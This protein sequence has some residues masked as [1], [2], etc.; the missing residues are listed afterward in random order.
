MNHKLPM[1]DL[2]VVAVLPEL[3]EALAGHGRAVLQ[4]PPG[5]GK[6]TLVP[7]F[8]LDQPW[9]GDRKTRKIQKIVMLEPRR[10]AAR[11]CAGF[12]ADLLGEAVGETVGYRIRNERRVSRR[13][14]IEVVT[15]GILTRMI[16][17]DPALSDIGALIFD[18]FHERHIQSDLGLALSLESAEVLR[19]DLKILVM[20]AT[21]DADALSA[22]MDGA[23][24]VR[25]QGRSWPVETI[26][27]PPDTRSPGPDRFRP[28]LAGC[29]AAVCH[30]LAANEGDIL[31]FLP[32][33]R[34]IRLTGEML[35]GRVGPDVR[36][37][38]LFGMLSQAD[39]VAAIS[40]SL[41]G[42]RKVV[43]ASAIAETSLTIEGVSI[44]VDSGLMRKPRF[45]PGTG[46]S[47]L[48]TLP[49]SRASADQRRGR[50]GRT[51]PGICYRIW[52]EHVH[53]GLIP[54][55]RP[56]ILS[57][58]LAGTALELALWGVSDP[59]GL[60]W[61]DLPPEAEFSRARD[62]LARLGALDGQ[63][64]ITGHGK[65][66]ARAGLHPRLAH[67][68][69]RA[70]RDGDGMLACRLAALLEERDILSTSDPDI[71]LRLEILETG[72]KHREM[73][74]NRHLVTTILKNAKRLAKNLAV[75]PGRA[76]TEA[77]AR[78]LAL[79]YPERVGK[80]RRDLVYGLASG[81][82]ACFRAPNTV[83]TSEYIVAAHLDGNPRNARIFL[84]APLDRADLE[85][86][87]GDSIETRD[88]LAWDPEAGAVRALRQTC[89]GRLVLDETP[90]SNPDPEAVKAA[91][92]AGIRQMGPGC[93]PWTRKLTG[94]CRRTRFLRENAGFGDLPDLE[95]ARLLATLEDWLAPFLDGIRSARDLKRLD[96]SAALSSLFT[97]DQQQTVRQQAPTHLTV[98]SGSKIPLKYTDGTTLLE[99]PVLAVRLQEMFG[100]TRTPAVGGRPVT[101]HLL[102]PAGRPVQVTR[103]LEN[104]WK[105][106]YAEVKK[107]LMGRY[108]KHYWPDDPLNAQPTNR[109]KPRKR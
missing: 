86:V 70:D 89:Y 39:Q 36:V 67:M 31:V 3:G 54:F 80:R 106:T 103:D 87:H 82:S 69:L 79:A 101:L 105:Q 21:M 32:G 16:Q 20:S 26:Y 81:N 63:G 109:A 59:G 57:E 66:I 68:I 45:F 50:A 84:A 13:T 34:E 37:M 8:L 92:M 41:P 30:A 2:P 62:L 22:L 107:D 100:L 33:A 44:V 60:K 56:E 11:A 5:A 85:A 65:R 47:R 73:G 55:T 19:E 76:D 9:L 90:V 98:P 71:R 97:W 23:P 38:P 91:M 93:L 78:V 49:V 96:L 40:P 104:F 77:A 25:S 6:T 94:L 28:V 10:L 46:T 14:R 52:S 99:S 53:K 24:V 42:R 61:L 12:M 1:P 29:A 83:S 27:R 17:A 64:R 48:E 18:E 95:D 72:G 51:G 108:P 88:H 43:L 4:A 15:E 74:V 58:D 102:S 35:A 7:L 75:K